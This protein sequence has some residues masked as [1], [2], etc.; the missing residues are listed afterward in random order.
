MKI[1][2]FYT[3]EE[4]VNDVL[5]F[6]CEDSIQQYFEQTAEDEVH[7]RK[8]ARHR[9][10]RLCSFIDLLMKDDCLSMLVD[11]VEEAIDN[12]PNGKHLILVKEED[13]LMAFPET[14]ESWT[15]VDTYSLEKEDYSAISDAYQAPYKKYL[16]AHYINN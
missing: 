4:Y 5:N 3:N 6:Y 8:I 11:S 10:S 14:F 9:D 13:S 12:E 7:A 2:D 16:A 1:N 15:L